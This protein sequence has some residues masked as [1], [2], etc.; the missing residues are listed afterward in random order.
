[1]EKKLMF[2]MF[3][4]VAIGLQITSAQFTI[5]LPKISKIKTD[6]T[7]TGESN[8]QKS[9]QPD[10]APTGDIETNPNAPAN[11]DAN[12]NVNDKAIA[13]D[14]FKDV[15]SVKILARSGTAY[16]TAKLDEPDTIRWYSLNSVYP[17]FDKQ[18]FDETMFDYKGY[19]APYLSCYTKKHNIDEGKVKGDGFFGQSNFSN[20]EEARQELQANQSKLAELDSLIKSKFASAPNIFLPYEE[21]PYIAAEIASQRGEYLNCVVAEVDSKP[22]FRLPVFLDFINKAKTEVDRYTPQDFLYL[23]SGGG[24]SDALLRAVSPK[25]RAEWSKEWLKNDDSRKEFNAAWDELAKAAAKKIPMYKPSPKDFQFRYPAGEKLL[26]DYFKNSSTL[27]I[28]RTG[29]D[30]AGWD[31]QKDSSNFP[32]YRYKDVRVYL[33]DSSDD[34]PYCRVVTARVKQDYAGGGTYNPKIYRSSVSEEVVGCP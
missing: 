1:M 16:K 18:A 22:D 15:E 2:A 26:M 17:Y 29:T 6:K 20:A 8:Q 33:R 12:L 25:A 30:T 7:K 34:F 11:Y 3:I 27:K 13:I 32:S 14:H 4:V 28:F 23:V 10:A 31:I 21:N 24:N 9:G 5:S 19:V